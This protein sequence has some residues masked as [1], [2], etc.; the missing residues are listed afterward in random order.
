M[1]GPDARSEPSPEALLECARS[2]PIN[3][4]LLDRLPSLDLPQCYLVAGC[5]FQAV[6]NTL[7][8]RPTDAG[9]RDYDVFYFDESDLSWEAEDRV[10]RRA[11]ELCRDLDAT[12][13]VRNQARVHLW[14]NDRFGEHCPQLGSSR[15]SIGGFLIPSTCVGI[16]AGSNEVH[17]PYGLEELWRGVLRI[18]PV[19]PQPKLFLAKAQSY[20][21]RWPWLTV[22]GPDI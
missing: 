21:E 14:F 11:A 3:R 22:V 19:R 1:R 4:A 2:N 18:N 6:W 8:G 7:S 5:V 16:E 15:E 20:R 12:I 17:A 10:I 13:E 9:V